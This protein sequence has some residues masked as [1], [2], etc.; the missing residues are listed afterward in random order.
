MLDL[1]VSVKVH[2]RVQ[3][4]VDSV[5]ACVSTFCIKTAY[6]LFNSIKCQFKSST[7]VFCLGFKDDKL[8]T[9]TSAYKKKELPEPFL[10]K[11]RS[12]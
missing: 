7:S 10:D 9:T 4:N 5:Q 6:M 8:I 1:I 11:Q 2:K 12:F 3:N